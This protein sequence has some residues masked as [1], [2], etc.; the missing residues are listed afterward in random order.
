MSFQFVTKLS[1]KE[2]EQL[3]ADFLK[4]DVNHD[5]GLDEEEFKKLMSCHVHV[6]TCLHYFAICSYHLYII[7]YVFNI[8]Y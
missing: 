3:Q 2:V 6:C 7:C 1:E 5:G 8:Y 4:A